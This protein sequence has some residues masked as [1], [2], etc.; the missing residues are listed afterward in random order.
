MKLKCSKESGSIR[1]ALILIGIT[2]A[3]LWAGGQSLYTAAMNRHPTTMSYE[4][5]VKTRPKATWLVLTNCSLHL[6]ESCFKS[7]YGGKNATELYVPVRSLSAEGKKDQKEQIHV[8]LATKD[9]NALETF[10]EMQNLKTEDAAV[11]WAL[12]NR[13][14][15]FMHRN[16]GGLVQFG[17]NLKD[18]ERRK[19][20]NLLQN[21]A[22]DFIILEEGAQPSFAE[23]LGLGVGGLMLAGA[24]ILY[25]RR[26][27]EATTADI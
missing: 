7:Y 12:K 26:N 10:S 24:M 16:V 20:A 9:P 1:L 27:R 21:A 4:E 17:I 6:T 2:A 22:D 25:V 23:G 19:L 8:V 15:I 14:R 3:M 18:T 13:N 11:L 5:Y